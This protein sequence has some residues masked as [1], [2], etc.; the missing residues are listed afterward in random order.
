MM[1]RVIRSRDSGVLVRL[2]KSM[3]RPHLEYCTVEWFPHYE[4]DKEMLE[5]VPGLPGSIHEDTVFFRGHCCLA[6]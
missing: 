5:R 2:Y 1:N 3:A 6:S 4:K